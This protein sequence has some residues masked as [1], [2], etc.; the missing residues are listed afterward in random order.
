MA[1]ITIDDCLEKVDNRFTLVHLAARRVRQ[2]QKGQKPMVDRNNRN[3]VLALREIAA[4]L[5][6]I[7]NI[8]AY[9]HVEPAESGS[10]MDFTFDEIEDD[11]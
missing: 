4:G 5:I 2:I 11:F 8:N 9:D 1:R 6:T 3:V 7:D 10:A